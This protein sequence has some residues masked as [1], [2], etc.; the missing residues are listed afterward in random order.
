[1]ALIGNDKSIAIENEIATKFERSKVRDRDISN[2]GMLNKLK[3]HRHFTTAIFIA[4][5]NPYH[6]NST[7]E[8]RAVLVGSGDNWI[9]MDTVNNEEDL[10]PKL[11]SATEIGNKNDTILPLYRNFIKSKTWDEASIYFQEIIQGT[12]RSFICQKFRPVLYVKCF[13]LNAFEVNE[14]MKLYYYSVSKELKK[15]IEKYEIKEL[16]QDSHFLLIQEFLEKKER[17]VEE[18]YT[19]LLEQIKGKS[20]SQLEPSQQQEQQA[21]EEELD[22]TEK[23][24]PKESI[25]LLEQQEYHP[26]I[27][28]L[29]QE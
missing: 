25:I 1:L 28:V 18:E 7:Y 15:E 22:S 17:Q 16:S 26:Q 20:I 19:E 23:Q 4:I 9:L 8:H 11:P 27:E 12:P 24:P 13:E 14:H 3:E 10:N 29:K 5:V 6:K 2:Q 21:I